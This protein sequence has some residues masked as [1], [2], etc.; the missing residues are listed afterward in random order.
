MHFG[1]YVSARDAKRIVEEGINE[2]T[3]SRTALKQTP[4]ETISFLKENRVSIRELRRRG[5]PKVLDEDQIDRIL[6]MKKEGGLSF[7]KIENLTGVAK[8]TAFDYYKRYNGKKLGKEKIFR[9]EREVAHS[10]FITLLRK[11]LCDEVNELAKRG[12]L[13]RDIGEMETLIREIRDIV[14]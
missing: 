1:N 7:K 6:T 10:V 11:D 5:R 2:I 4:K 8:S 13:S 14:Y 12:L 3:M 9:I